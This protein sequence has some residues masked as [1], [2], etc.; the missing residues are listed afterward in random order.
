MYKILR[1]IR[2][3]TV[4]E[5]LIASFLSFLVAGASLHFYLSQHKSWM[6]QNDVADV[7]Q[8]A[9][10]SLDE[11]ASHLRMAGYETHTY[12]SFEVNTNSL[13]V[14]TVRDS[15]IDTIRYFVGYG[16]YVSYQEDAN[17]PMLFRRINHNPPEIFAEGVETLNVKQLTGT[18]FEI[19]VTARSSKKEE[20][21]IDQDGH[22]RRVLTTRVR[23]RNIPS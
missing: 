16:D 23:I 3:I 7:Q 5:M 17:Q 22:R 21:V 15:Q 14:Y 4:L 18:L 9:R 2:G 20:K 11:I 19:A 6:T 8:N 10:A 1:D 13:T 12:P